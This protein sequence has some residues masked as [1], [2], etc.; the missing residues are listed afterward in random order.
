MTMF[1]RHCSGPVYWI[2]PPGALT[3]TECAHC[4]QRNCQ[5]EVQDGAIDSDD[6]DSEGGSHD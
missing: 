2:G 3:H 6:V 4:H 1:C 5:I